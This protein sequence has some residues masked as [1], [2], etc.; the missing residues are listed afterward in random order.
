MG[1]LRVLPAIDEW[2]NADAD[3]WSP[4]SDQEYVTLV[5][6]WREEYLP[7]ISARSHSFQGERAMQAIAAR[8][9]S[10]VLLFSGVKVPELQNTGGRGAAAYR[11]A[12]LRS[13]E[14]KMANRLELILAAHDLSW[15]CVF[16]HEAGAFVWESLYQRVAG[17]SAPPDRSSRI[18]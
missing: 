9:P 1:I 5:S 7:L 18:V 12:G 3:S 4:I 17:L 10:D 14:R 15:T 6:Q 11:A 8:L 13:V 2:L 16:S